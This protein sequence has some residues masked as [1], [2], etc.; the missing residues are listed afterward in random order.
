MSGPTAV[1]WM[2]LLG[3]LAGV[4]GGLFGIGGGL[5]IVPVLVL[6]F[7]LDQKTATGTSLFALLWPVGVLGVWEYWRR[8]EL[9]VGYG[10]W[11]AI[12]L[13][14]GIL[15]GAKLTRPMSAAQLK[16]AYGIFLLIVGAYYLIG[17]KG[18]AKPPTPEIP[19]QAQRPPERSS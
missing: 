16:R 3:T 2:L 6:G 8:G 18:S 19:V 12:G 15:I 7:G 5:V 10:A 4:L 11:I 17:T 14:L 1:M 13:V 9:R